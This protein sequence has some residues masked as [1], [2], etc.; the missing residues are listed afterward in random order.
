M[1][2]YKV[3]YNISLIISM[4]YEKDVFAVQGDVALGLTAPERHLGPSTGLGSSADPAVAHLQKPTLSRTW[5]FAILIRWD[6]PLAGDI[7][8]GH[9]PSCV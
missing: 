3:G 5:A 7:K 8:H 6:G 4:I 1:I 9:V 2:N